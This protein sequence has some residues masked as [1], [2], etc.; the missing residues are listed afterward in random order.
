MKIEKLICNEIYKFVKE[1]IDE[2]ENK[3]TIW[4]DRQT[5]QE[6]GFKNRIDMLK[7]IKNDVEVAVWA[8]QELMVW[9]MSPNHNKFCHDYTKE[10]FTEDISEEESCTIYKV[11]NPERHFTTK[12]N[13]HTRITSITEVKRVTKLVEVTKWEAL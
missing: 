4:G 11:G 9:G 8:L 12:Y 13:R 1:H 7:Q 10:L 3:L 2:V 5:Y 6:L